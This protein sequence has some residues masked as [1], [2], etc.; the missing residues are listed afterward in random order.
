MVEALIRWHPAEREP[1]SVHNKSRSFV[2]D[3]VAE[4]GNFRHIFLFFPANPKCST[5]TS[6]LSS[7]TDAV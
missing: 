5:Y 6:I 4:G 3:A 7:V 1:V 2:L